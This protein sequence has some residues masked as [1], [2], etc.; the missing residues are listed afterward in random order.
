MSE[1][2]ILAEDPYYMTMTQAEVEAHPNTDHL[3]WLRDV[4]EQRGDVIQVRPNGYYEI[5]SLGLN[6]GTGHGWN[7]NKFILIRTISTILRSRMEALT[8]SSLEKLR[9]FGVDLDALT[10]NE[11]DVYIGETFITERTCQV[12][13]ITFVEKTL[14]TLSIKD[15]KNG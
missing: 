11:T 10:I 5:P 9:R 4:G 12:D 8:N 15:I 7:R 6:I 14:S 3:N 2:L 1:L 13:N